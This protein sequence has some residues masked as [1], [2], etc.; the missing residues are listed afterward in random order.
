MKVEQK[1]G[2][3]IP[4]KGDLALLNTPITLTHQ[5]AKSLINN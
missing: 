4:I 3:N 1:A 5:E 2:P